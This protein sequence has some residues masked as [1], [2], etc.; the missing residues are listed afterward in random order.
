[1]LFESMNFNND[2][3]RLQQWNLEN[4][5]ILSSLK[6]KAL[7]LSCSVKPTL[8]LYGNAI[9]TVDSHKDLVI[10]LDKKFKWNKHADAKLV[11]SRRVFYCLKSSIPFNTD[12]NVKY[13]LFR[14]Y[15]L[16][17]LFYGSQ[18]WHDTSLIMKLDRFQARC[19]RWIF[20]Q[21]L[22]YVELLRR[23]SFYD[24]FSCNY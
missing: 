10:I 13:D 18:V 17:I 20:D 2:P 16:S 15:D 1:M 22:S 4:G 21:R 3:T 11:S 5:M 8:F 19:F 12:S 14:C 6:T 24:V 7:V 9:E 23:N